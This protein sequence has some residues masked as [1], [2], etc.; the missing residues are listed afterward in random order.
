MITLVTGSTGTIGSALVDAL[1]KQGRAV[2]CLVRN[3]DKAVRVLPVGI[4]PVRGDLTDE[5]SIHAAMQGVTHVFHAGG[6]PEQWTADPG[7][8]ERV[9]VG[10]TAAMIAAATA[11]GVASFVYTSTQDIFDLTAD[12]FDETM[13]GRVPLH[14]AYERSKQAAEKLVEA[15][16][17]R[18]LPARFIHPVAVYGPGAGEVT[19]LNSLIERLL[20]NQVPVLLNGG[21]PV[22][23]NADV[24]RGHLLAEAKA[25]AGAHFILSDSIQSLQAIAA[26]VNHIRPAARQPKT[27]PDWIA[28]LLAN[29]GEL[30]SALT[31]RKPLVSKG[32][33]GVLQRKG[34]P[35]SA[36]ARVALDWQTTPFSLGV[37]ATIKWLE[38]RHER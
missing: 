17:T 16:V 5:A 30:I 6:M 36:R 11:A 32:E 18:G 15:A 33:L 24:A 27:M 20:R 38:N 26:T 8:F 12:P 25:A 22:V 2:R 19:G 21:L 7:I 35:S 23:F 13:P 4:E 29:G 1:V 34:R 31:G 3:P 28:A 14:S 9:N 10:G 37:E